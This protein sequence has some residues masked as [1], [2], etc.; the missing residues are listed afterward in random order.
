MTLPRMLLLCLLSGCSVRTG[1]PAADE[2]VVRAAKAIVESRLDDAEASL[3]LALELDPDSPEARANLGLVLLRRGELSAASTELA[4][5]L[6]LDRD[7]AAAHVTLGNLRVAEGR[8]AEAEGC[9]VAA[10]RIQPELPEP[11]RNLVLLLLSARRFEEARAHALRLA[12]LEPDRWESVALL[13]TAELELGRPAAAHARLTE[14][15]HD[16]GPVP[17]L[18]PLLRH[19]TP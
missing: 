14:F 11:R 6:A 15:E 16:F 8:P 17:D 10:L 5:A 18:A 1:S 3:R 4:R 19:S 9:Y 12:Q 7:L 13:A 2:H